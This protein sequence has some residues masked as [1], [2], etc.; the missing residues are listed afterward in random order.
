M[1]HHSRRDRCALDSISQSILIAAFLWRAIALC[2]SEPL[3]TPCW[4]SGFV[5]VL[6][7]VGPRSG[8]TITDAFAKIALFVLAPAAL[9]LAVFAIHREL[10][11]MTGTPHG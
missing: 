11:R 2:I 4:I 9:T 8:A 3:T 5:T 6:S 7:L 10:R 1:C